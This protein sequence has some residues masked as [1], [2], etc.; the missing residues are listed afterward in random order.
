VRRYLISVD[1]DALD[2]SAPGDESVLPIRIE[3][4]LRGTLINCREAEL[5]GARIV[6]DAPRQDGTRVYIEADGVGPHDP[7]IAGSNH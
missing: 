4:T 1:R 2:K 6:Y 5:L 7:F 3:D